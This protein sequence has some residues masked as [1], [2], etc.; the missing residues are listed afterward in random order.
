M[1]GLSWWIRDHKRLVAAVVCVGV[2]VGAYQWRKHCLSAFEEEDYPALI[3]QGVAFTLNSHAKK[4]TIVSHD[5][6]F[7]MKEMPSR[8]FGGLDVEMDKPLLF[9]SVPDT[10]A[11]TVTGRTNEPEHSVSRKLD[12]E[13]ALN[14]MRSKGCW[15]RIEG[16]YDTNTGIMATETAIDSLSVWSLPEGSSRKARRDAQEEWEILE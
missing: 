3:R 8:W 10:I 13:G 4:M 16:T 7:D 12:N 11:F 5:P 14:Y 9:L 2:F 1:V 6:T 15:I